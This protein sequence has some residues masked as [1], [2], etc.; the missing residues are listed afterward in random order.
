MCLAVVEVLC[1]EG[2]VDGS[3]GCRREVCC[4]R[5]ECCVIVREWEREEGLTPVMQD[6]SCAVSS[7]GG[8]KCWGYNTWG[9]VMI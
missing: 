5:H 8:L 3:A 6:H 7:E 9:Q 2:M 4:V 1:G